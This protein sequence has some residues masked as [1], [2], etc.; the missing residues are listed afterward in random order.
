MMGI[1][2]CTTVESINTALPL[3][4]S[5]VERPSEVGLECVSDETY[6]II[7]KAYKR[8]ETLENIIKSTH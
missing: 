1:A 3:P 8:I 2:S 6:E 7:V 5:A 4:A